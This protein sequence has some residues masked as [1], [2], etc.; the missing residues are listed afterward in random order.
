M[1]ETKFDEVMKEM[2]EVK[3][4]PADIVDDIYVSGSGTTLKVL[5]ISSIALAIGA[6]VGFAVSRLRK[7]KK[8]IE[9]Q[10]NTLD[11]NDFV[12]EDK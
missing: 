1:E 11:E 3:K 5:A 8:Y 2:E 6:G 9:R 4:V 7:R 12:N 10:D